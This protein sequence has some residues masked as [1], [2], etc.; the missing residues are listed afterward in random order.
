M[1]ILHVDQDVRLSSMLK[2]T[3][4]VLKMYNF[5]LGFFL[6]ACIFKFILVFQKFFQ[7]LFLKR[8]SRPPEIS[9]LHDPQSYRPG[10]K[11]GD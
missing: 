4:E 6:K 9:F 8:Q 11:G 10:G 7:F 2:L 1:I 5:F 3:L